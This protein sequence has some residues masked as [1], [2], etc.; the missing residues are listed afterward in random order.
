MK[1]VTEK[2][3]WKNINHETY[4]TYVFSIDNTVTIEKPKLLNVSD[5]GGHRILDS[6]NVSHY[7]PSGWIHLFWETK[8]TNAFRF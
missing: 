6:K 7:I 1:K 8:D 2:L 3:N 5:S 4:R